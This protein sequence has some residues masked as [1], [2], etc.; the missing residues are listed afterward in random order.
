VPG[1]L[2]A[3]AL[4]DLDGDGDIDA[5]VADGAGGQVIPLFNARGTL[6]PG[7]GTTAV[8]M[9]TAIAAGALGGFAKDVAV[10]GGGA[11][12]QVVIL[13]NGEGSLFVRTTLDAPAGVA[14]VAIGDVDRDGQGDVVVGGSGQVLVY[15]N[16]GDG[17]F[18]TPGTPATVGGTASGLALVDLDGDASLDL[19]ASSADAGALSVLRNDGQGVLGG[20]TSVPVPGATATAGIAAADLDH[21]GDAD[22]V[23]A[24]DQ[25]LVVFTGNGAGALQ[26]GVVVTA[27]ASVVGPTIVFANGDSRPDVAAATSDQKV[28]LALGDGE[29]CDSPDRTAC[30]ADCTFAGQPVWARAG[31]GAQ[32]D[33]ATDVA[34]D[35]ADNVYVVGTFRESLTIGGAPA[36]PAQGGSDFFVASFRPDGTLRWRSAFGGKADDTAEGVTVSPFGTVF[37]VGRSGPASFGSAGDIGTDQ[38]A[39]A[40]ALSAQDGTPFFVEGFLNGTATGT[41]LAV[42][43]D[44]SGSG[45]VGGRFDGM[46]ATGTTG[47]VGPGGFLADLSSGQIFATFTGDPADT[48]TRVRAVGQ[49]VAALVTFAGTIR[50]LAVASEGARDLAV[51]AYDAARTRVGTTIIGGAGD[52]VPGDLVACPPSLFVYTGFTGAL[53][54]GQTTLTAQGGADAALVTFAGGA[55]TAQAQATAAAETTNAIVCDAR[56]NL[57]V[58][59]NLS[60][61]GAA[62]ALGSLAPDGTPRWGLP[63]DLAPARFARDSLGGVYIAGSFTA[64]FTW[65]ADNLAPAGGVD[66]V[67]AKLRP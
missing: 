62:A 57:V 9:P 46:L 7:Q 12:P 10:V 51:V 16:N 4:G 35:A 45:I 28:I 8:A 21:D 50:E 63:S 2:V 43:A 13:T 5:V 27:P 56:G 67:L 65:G 11:T 18:V 55:V 1:D 64:S 30:L 15:R 39:Y 47:V 17:G 33:V 34:V 61:A 24:A 26:A 22:V 58:G 37:V 19:V 66:A 52:A 29:E 44:A 48:V 40:L 53:R 20:G 59:G 31:G 14:S 32:D 36:L 41:A 60:F 3:I 23:V 49:N 6:T 54:A 25:R 38:Q 42:A